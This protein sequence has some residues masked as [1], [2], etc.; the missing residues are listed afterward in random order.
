MNFINSKGT[1]KAIVISH[2]HFYTTHLE[3][4][5]QFNCP[6]YIASDDA[7]WLSREDRKGV[8]RWIKGTSE[9]IPGVTAIQCGGHFDGSGVLHW[10]NK[11]FI[12]D[13][14]M[15][16]PVR[17][18]RFFLNHTHLKREYSVDAH[19]SGFYN[20]GQAKRDQKTT[21]FSFMWSYP[22]MI[23]LPPNEIHGIWK[24]LKPFEFDT[25]YGGFPGQNV[26]RK[27]LKKQV[28]E[29]MKIFIK[30]GGHE[31]ARVLEETY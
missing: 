20:A 5:A 3:W 29:S 2:P 15:S 30:I 9:I 26:T 1:L 16:V 14:M 13:T 21:T 24:A 7:E 10:E 4:A 19:Q 17:L 28:L 11:L 31:T 18:P 12:A 27:D 6:V 23:P 25:T 8:R 22:N